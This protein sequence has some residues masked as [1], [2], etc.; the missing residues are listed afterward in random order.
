MRT[1]TKIL[2][3]AGALA[4]TLVCGVVTGS[5]QSDEFSMDP[6]EFTQ[7]M[8]ELMMQQGTDKERAKSAVDQLSRFMSNGNS[9]MQDLLMETCNKMRKKKARVFPDYVNVISVFDQMSKTNRINGHNFEVWKAVLDSK[10]GNL[11]KLRNFLDQTNSYETQGAI[12]SSRSVAWRVMDLDKVEFIDA[13][14]DLNYKVGQTT[15]RCMSQNDSIDIVE[16]SGMYFGKTNKWL[17]NEGRIT[18][19]RVGLDASQ[20]YATFGFYSIDTKSNEVSVDNCNFVNKNYFD[21]PLKG[22]VTHKCLSRK[23]TYG[24]RYPK[25]ETDQSSTLDIPD[26]FD[27]VGF[28]GGF[29]QTGSSFKGSGAYGYPAEVYIH[30]AD[31]VLASFKAQTFNVSRNGIEGTDTEVDIALGRDAITHPGL[32]FRYRDD[33]REI[34]LTR[35]NQGADRAKYRDT[36]HKMLI[37]ANLIKWNIDGTQIF[38]TQLAGS[39]MN[40]A[41]FESISYYNE[42]KYRE[43]WG[44]NTKHPMQV[45]ADFTRYNG[46]GAFQVKDFANF[47][48]M[49]EVQAQQLLL[50]LSYDGFVDY[51]TISNNK[52]A[53]ATERLYDYLKFDVGKKDYDEM[54]FISVDSTASAPNGYIDLAD[55]NFHMRKV[56]GVQIS[57]SENQNIYLTPANGD[58]VL[59]KN[60]NIDYDGKV[61]VGQV[62]A[63]GTNFH[64]D[65]DAFL[66]KLDSIKEMK[67]SVT[68]STDFRRGR[69]QQKTLGST[70]TD[71]SGV[72]QL[73][74]PANKSGK[75]KLTGYPK[76]SSTTPAKIYYPNGV[77]GEDGATYY[78]DS[79]QFYFQVDTFTFEDI[80]NI[81]NSNL[82]FTGVLHTN[83]L[84]DIRHELSI[85]PDGSLG[86]QSKTPEEG[87]PIYGGKATFYKDFDLS[88]HGLRGIGDITYSASKSTSYAELNSDGSFE[89]VADRE[90]FYFMQK[91]AEGNTRQFDVAK[92][93]VQPTFPKVELGSNQTHR[94]ANNF[95]VPG[96]SQM[97]FYPEADRMEFRN[98]E[99]K[100][101]MFPN[102]KKDEYFECKFDGQLNVTPTGLKGIGHGDLEIISERG[103]S[104]SALESRAVI[105]TD[106]TIKAD[107]SYFIAFATGEDQQEV[108]ASGELRR[109]IINKMDRD[110]YAAKSSITRGKYVNTAIREDSIVSKVCNDRSKGRRI[111]RKLISRSQETFID[112]DKREGRFVY[113]SAGGNEKDFSAIKYTTMV[114][115]YTWDLERGEETI[116]TSGTA[117]N[118]FVCTKERG[119]S[120]NFLVP[121]AIFDRNANILRCEEVKFI[122][123]ADAKVNLKVGDVVTIH[124][125][126]EMEELK[127]THVDVRADSTAS[128]HSFD[129]ANITILGAKQY[130]G[131]G[132]YTFVDN[133]GGK[134]VIFMG[135]IHTEDAIT[136]AKGLV[137]DD[138]PIDKYF[139]F[140]GLTNLVG[141]RKLLEFDGGAKM[142]QIGKKGPRTYIRFSSILDPA[143]VKIPVDKRSFDKTEG[144]GK[145]KVDE[146]YHSFRIA[147]DSTHIYSTI[148]ERYKDASDLAMVAAP[149]GFLYHNNI[150]DRYEINSP[151]KI[152]K[153]DTIGTYM[154]YYPDEDA[155]TAFGQVDLRVFLTKKPTGK[156]DFRSAGDLRHDRGQNVITANLLTEMYFYMHP[157][158]TQMLYNDIMS[159]KAP[160]CDSTSRRYEARMAEL[161]DTA[162]VNGIKRGLYGGF[163][164]KTKLMLDNGPALTF[165]G[166][167]LTWS[168]EKKCYVCDTT[169][170]LMMMHYNP[171]YRKVKMQA[172]FFVRKNGGSRVRM[173]MTIDPETWYYIDFRSGMGHGYDR[174]SVRS[175]NPDVV[176]TIGTIDIR[177]RRNRSRSTECLI[178][179][180]DY[181][182]KFMEGFGLNNIPDDAYAQA[183]TE[184]IMDGKMPDEET[185]TSEEEETDTEQEE[186]E[187]EE[188]PDEEVEDESQGEEQAEETEEEV[189]DEPVQISDY[190]GEE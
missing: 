178:A 155:V 122:N 138:M 20:V 151:D 181:L 110:I 159:S 107:T 35:S 11:N 120:L 111:T 144:N 93:T 149:E 34:E 86:F 46:G 188:T 101:H 174:L 103:L 43:L 24:T 15:L 106:H 8:S 32:S 121:V 132:D 102:T 137:Q 123:V 81:T 65:Y 153:P 71:M 187:A 176:Q 89:G 5:R 117:G 49:T 183:D 18:W 104:K 145:D 146:I 113:N 53:K 61:I 109:D 136:T 47:T 173:K 36:Y 51:Y 147:K 66:I 150:F 112:F 156:F 7:Q 108:V 80:N 87:Y 128:Y 167:M 45:V 26:L 84:P 58:I 16:T 125:N 30:K 67:M 130:K 98:M 31:T 179:S 184:D 3:A 13:G 27:K 177:D 1:Y 164:P 100:F 2:I 59:K 96:K 50:Q 166:M 162:S 4:L 29:T 158:V 14:G 10:C 170:N 90:C 91:H 127:K 74:D 64:F 17:G 85:R 160:K 78:Y 94:D 182:N 189:A 129:N 124:K 139:A 52:V 131:Y 97:K 21:S 140:K 142:R 69:F 9:Q 48:G 141:N 19:E 63:T 118:R 70:L 168:T 82:P 163:D 154:C 23:T 133:E 76:L 73:N 38:I 99:G 88:N 60:R 172:E 185:E 190:L 75:Q 161:Y 148:M 22:T 171:I 126:A 143:K 68:D 95:A 175:S 116:G 57:D 42:E 12:Y 180:E 83:I 25:F 134:N 186:T 62:T 115:N 92:S 54:R 119:D 39:P 6:T 135:D 55:L 33:T 169:V 152:A 157:Q 79:A 105:F 165:D 114:K 28:K 56:Q 41:Y 37:E 40:I 77:Q 72:V 44:M